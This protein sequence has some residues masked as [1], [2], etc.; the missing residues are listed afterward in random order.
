[1]L[2]NT[3]YGGG[4]VPLPLDDDED[5]HDDEADDDAA[6]A[7]TLSLL[8]PPPA[9]QEAEDP[10]LEATEPD[11]DTPSSSS[12]STGVARLTVA[13]AQEGISG[14]TAVTASTLVSSSS[15]PSSS[16]ESR[17][18]RGPRRLVASLKKKMHFI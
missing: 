18:G 14:A 12:L 11:L 6:A 16:V 3:S 4:G 9:L 1:M 17:T 15:S 8:P 5:P 7:A 13:V 2:P 10:R